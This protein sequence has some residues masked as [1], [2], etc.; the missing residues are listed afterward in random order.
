MEFSS[1]LFLFQFVELLG[2]RAKISI[3]LSLLLKDKL[4]SDEASITH[5]YRHQH[6]KLPNLAVVF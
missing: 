6:I 5:H 2:D 4:L 1:A 3:I